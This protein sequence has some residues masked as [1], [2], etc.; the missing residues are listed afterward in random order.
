M[1]DLSIQAQ[2][3]RTLVD[4]IRS[5]ISEH[6]FQSRWIL[7]DGYWK[8]GKI[9]SETP[10]ITHSL[11]TLAVDTGISERTLWYAKRLFELYPDT[12]KLPE[13]KNITWNKLITKYLPETPKVEKPIH[14]CTCPICGN[15][16][17]TGTTQQISEQNR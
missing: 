5:T 1:A 11:Q 12:S 3:Y 2:E 7:V 15:L 14:M 8:V 17:N 10:N 9:L 4:E 13:G 16:H 6:L